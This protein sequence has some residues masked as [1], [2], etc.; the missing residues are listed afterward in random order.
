ME[1]PADDALVKAAELSTANPASA[2]REAESDDGPLADAEGAAE[3]DPLGDITGGLAI[4]TKPDDA[5]AAAAV[6]KA[7]S[8]KGAPAA[9]PSLAGMLMT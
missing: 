4:V 8:N 7:G 5:A 6:G 1:N 2:I 9:D 3:A